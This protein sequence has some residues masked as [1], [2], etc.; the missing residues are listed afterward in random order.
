MKNKVCILTTVHH[1]FDIRI[2]YKEAKTLVLAGHKVTLI[3]Q[4]NKNE[5]IDDIQI[6]ALSKPRNR[7]MRIFGLTW[8]T[9]FLALRQRAGIYHF[10]DPE[11]I[12][13]GILLKFLGKKV[14][15]DVHED[16]QKQ[17]MN[18]GWLGNYQ[19][20]KFAAFAINIIEQMGASLFNKIVA[21]TPDIARRFPKNKTVILRNFSILKLIDNAIPANYK[22]NKPLIIYAGGLSKI[23]GIKE[24]IQA[25]EYIG[26]RAELL[27]LGKWES[28][29]FKKECENL[30]GWKYTKYL[31]HKSL[32]EVYSCLKISQ[33]GISILYPVKNYLAS[34]PVKTFEYMACLLPVVMSNFPYW[35]EIFKGFALF[36]NP[37]DPKDIAEKISYLLDNPNEAKK[38]GKKGRKLIEEKYSWETESKKL[39]EMYEKL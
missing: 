19:I 7:F 18:K 36:V 39:L 27:L 30:N 31:G 26:D 23:R 12:F 34:L 14:I 32:E 15:Y 1:L 22:K 33:V 8:E 21:A 6:I 16:V 28:E 10:H 3:A 11:L 35:Q 29:K 9:L 2:F 17:I 25:M 37:Y 4:H 5:I 24:V 38:L 20:R 13:I